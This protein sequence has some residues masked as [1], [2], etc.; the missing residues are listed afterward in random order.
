MQGFARPTPGALALVLVLAA[1]APVRAQQ[2]PPARPPQPPQI[3]QAAQPTAKPAQP[4]AMPAPA[5]APRPAPA[6]VPG[7][8]YI[9]GIG[10]VL[11]ISVWGNK[12]LDGEIAVRPDGR[13]SFPLAGE[14]D[15]KGLSVPQLTE[16]LTARLSDAV[17]SPNVSIIVKEV[18]SFRVFIVGQI[19][20][21]GVYP[22]DV[23]TPLLEALTLAGGPTDT[24]D[25]PAAYIIRGEKKI[26]TD[27]RKL[28][29]GGDLSQNPGLQPGDNI[30]VPQ[31]AIGANPQE[32]F[33]QRIYILGKVAKPGVYNIKKNVPILHA[34]FLAGGVVEG[35][36]DLPSAFVVRGTQR[37]PVNLWQLIQKGD[38]SQNIEIRA[39]DTIVV[40]VGG[41]LQNAV[42]VMGEVAKPG[43]YSQPEAL[44][45]LKLV[46]LA[47]G[48]TKF[49]APGRATLIRK[50]GN[51]KTSIAVDL[52]E[53][54][55][56]PTKNEDMPLQPGDVLIVPERLF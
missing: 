47:G 44:T 22:I 25:L 36:A 34:L 31:I 30:V 28:M 56:D 11:R 4:A 41:E 23:G 9:I 54:M 55:S 17:K 29:Q 13:I 49:A 21:P 7:K 16:I 50:S 8:D 33:D 1:V 51:E 6:P 10:D 19:Q 15:A 35:A 48:F 5:A 45:L 46:A 24:A 43:V 14:M 26:P 3:G 40:P 42:Y 38:L 18:R 2:P 39:E 53:V 12:D 32:I 27:L 52:R 37:I 20:K